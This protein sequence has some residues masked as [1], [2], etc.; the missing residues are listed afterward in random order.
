MKKFVLS[1]AT[2]AL[3]VAS[4]ANNNNRYNVK[5]FLPGEVGGQTVKAGEYKLELKDNQAVLTG[6]KGTVEA[7]AQVQEGDKKFAQ[8]VVKYSGNDANAKIEEI[9]IG[10]TSKT[11]VFSKAQVSGN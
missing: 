7:A 6:A 11:V 8:T 3:A 10:G 5:L 1:F 2:L 4:A 9:R